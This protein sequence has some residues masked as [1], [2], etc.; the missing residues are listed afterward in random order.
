MKWASLVIGLVAAASGGAMAVAM[1]RTSS[2]DHVTSL[3][4]TVLVLGGL[5]TT[6]YSLAN[7]LPES[8]AVEP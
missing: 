5:F 6:V 8:G 1:E 3:V 4:A 7:S 2:W